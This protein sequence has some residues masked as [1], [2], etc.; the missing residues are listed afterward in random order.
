MNINTNSWHFKLI[1]VVGPNGFYTQNISTVCTYTRL[2]CLSIFVVVSSI[3]LA[4]LIAALVILIL[5]VPL[6]SSAVPSS[7]LAMFG[8][9][10]VGY[11]S[12][13]VE[14]DFREDIAWNINITTPNDTIKEP[15]L[16][17]VWLKDEHDKFC[18]VINFEDK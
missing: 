5:F 10:I 7:L 17:M 2:L 16:F 13:K 8:W 6:F 12:L 9:F 11:F 1:S 3:M 4:L 18:T 14:N 15:N